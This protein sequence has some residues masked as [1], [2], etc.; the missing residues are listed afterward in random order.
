[1]TMPSV[2][3]Q[4]KAGEESTAVK[5]EDLMFASIFVAAVALTMSMLVLAGPL[6]QLLPSGH[7]RFFPSVYVFIHHKPTE[8]MRYLLAV[9]FVLGLGLVFALVRTPR[10]LSAT[11]A[12][13]TSVRW[14]G[15]CGLIACAGVAFWSWEAQFENFGGEGSTTH[16]G[17]GDLVVAI[18]IAAALVYLARLRPRW[19]D[20]RLL[21]TRRPQSWWWLATA[22]LLTACWLLPSIFRAQNLGRADP[23]VTFHLQFTFDEFVSVVNGRT[24]LV[25]YTDQ[26]ASLLPFL[27][28]PVLSLGGAQVGVFT[29]TMC[30]LTFVAL[31]CVER[32]LALVTRNEI[33]ALALYVPF[34]ASSL[35]FI[36]RGSEPFNWASYY[37]VFPVRY[38]GPYV[39][40]WMCTRHIRGFRPHGSVVVFVCA[41]FVVLNNVEFGLPA[42]LA[43][44]V[45]VLTGAE[46]TAA[47]IGRVVRNLLAG[48]VIAFAAVSVLTL[49]RA[50][51][52][53][54]L[55]MLTYFA[56][57]FGEGGYGLIATP[58][59]GLYMV[60][61]MTFGAAVLMGALRYRARA[62]DKTLTAALLYSGILGL[63]A[64]NYYM[65][66]THPAGLVV[67]FSIWAISVA[68]LALL[69]L[70]AVA[71]NRVGAR[72]SSLAL[73]GSA[74]LS[75]GV[76][77]TSI[78]QFP[79]PWTEL[80]RITT[81]TPVPAPY[82][83]G[84][85]VAFVRR[86]S[87]RGEPVLLLAPLGHQIAID[88]H[89]ENIASVS[90]PI[91]LLTYEQLAEALASLKAT[92]GTRIY[93][94]GTYAEVNTALAAD[95]FKP[96]VDAASGMTEWW[97]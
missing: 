53:P 36:I 26:Y 12:R 48:F 58:L 52:L 91:N 8:Q 3:S 54:K 92:Q 6:G 74:L 75:L 28:W 18:V 1:M 83:I 39:L 78:A 71:A 30:V 55:G 88:A 73:V 47:G 35:F 86:T 89:V 31:L 37:A 60:V 90:N 21:L 16:F 17:E 13:R 96:T 45:V 9:A 50:G 69:A 82:A 97:R 20:A 93:A 59:G 15:L 67:L 2:E 40:F 25:N 11:Q 66:R 33:L 61:D 7:F 80:R 77:G 44:F 38:L 24:P 14:L 41:G 76:A 63:G 87:H 42:L 85:A 62:P 10:W 32:A 57:L 51:Q 56:R 34:L 29:V 23:Y 72:L 49:L 65:G 79:K 68:L 64:G 95:G 4:P 43:A 94:F 5:R 70:R 46:R 19:F 81:S 22:A 27:V 84:A